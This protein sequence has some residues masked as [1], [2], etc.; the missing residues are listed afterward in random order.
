MKFIKCFFIISATKR[1]REFLP[2]NR[3]HESLPKIKR[4]S[5]PP[6]LLG[7]F[8]NPSSSRQNA[9]R[10]EKTETFKALWRDYKTLELTISSLTLPSAVSQLTFHINTCVQSS[11][12]QCRIFTIGSSMFKIMGSV[13]KQVKMIN[14][15]LSKN[16]IPYPHVSRSN[17]LTS[18]TVFGQF[19]FI[20][21]KSNPLVSPVRFA[22]THKTRMLPC[23]GNLELPTKS[24]PEKTS[25]PVAINNCV[26]SDSRKRRIDSVEKNYTNG[27]YS[28][29]I[30]KEP[31]S[32]Y[33]SR[34]KSSDDYTKHGNNIFSVLNLKLRLIVQ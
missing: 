3:D 14:Q 12:V 1:R 23:Y 22:P 20:V 29:S 13:T 25:P 34:R 26:K 28:S 8:G 27:N 2:S 16:P 9:V 19:I 31:S 15:F 18:P 33:S 32:V 5:E 24:K 17:V 30:K 7:R 11:L 21:N 4:F 6:K 10:K